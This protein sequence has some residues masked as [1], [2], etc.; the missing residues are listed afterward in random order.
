M[1]WLKLNPQT[2][3]TLKP[4]LQFPKMFPGRV[5]V[6]TWAA[7]WGLWS[8][9][10]LREW[11]HKNVL[12]AYP[13]SLSRLPSRYQSTTVS[14]FDILSHSASTRLIRQEAFQ[15]K[16]ILPAAESKPSSAVCVPSWSGNTM[17][18]LMSVECYLPAS[19]AQSSSCV[20]PSQHECGSRKLLR[21]MMPSGLKTNLSCRA[22]VWTGQQI[23]PG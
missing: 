6:L 18:T 1:F 10:W 4:S 8:W 19:A 11:G 14:M 23:L 13:H 20:H 5:L 17:K 3:K 7:L 9:S 16:V 22:A 21:W 12:Q 2:T 15:M